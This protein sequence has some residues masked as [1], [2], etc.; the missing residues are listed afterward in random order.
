MKFPWMQFFATDWLNDPLVSMCEPATR[1]ILMDWLCNMHLL[2]R[3][4]QIT[5][6]R[7]QLARLGRCN[8]VQV[9]SALQDLSITKAADVTERNGV[10][11]VVNRRMRREHNRRNGSKIRMSRMRG[12]EPCYASVTR[13]SH[14]SESES[15]TNNKA[16]T[17]PERW[18]IAKAM[19]V[20]RMESCLGNQWENDRSKWLK[21][22]KNDPCK[23]ERVIA[24]VESAA[25]ESRI[26]TTPA[27]YAE[28]IWK[29]FE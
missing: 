22:I 21:N 7:E 10:V 23:S 20:S 8:A 19:L 12:S 13:Q 25:K 4:G 11:T 29:E 5:G 15:D 3:I 26:K 9:E 24:E 27:Q 18:P 16:S 28:Q 1:G 6:T 14:K 17:K 2:D